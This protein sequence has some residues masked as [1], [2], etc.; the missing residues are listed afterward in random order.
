MTSPAGP[1][2]TGGDSGE[3]RLKLLAVTACPTG[4]AHTYM[5]A[6]KLAQAA[7]SRGIDMKVETQ[8]SIGAENV[9]DDNDVSSA[10]GIII[11][12]D[13]DV[14][15]SR[16]VGKRVL[17]VGVAEGIRHPEQLIERVRSAPVHTAGAAPAASASSGGRERS[18][19][20][21]ALMNGV[22]Y[23]IPFVVV[24]GLLIAIS[25]SL[26]GHTD[27]SGGLVIPKD[28][29]WMDVNNI[30]VIGFTL[31]VPILSGYIAYAIGDRPA[32]VPGMIGGWIANT[33]E[34]YDSKAGA[35]F[36]GAIVTGFLAGYLVLWIK[37]VK[38]PKFVQ[39]IMPIIVIPIVA[40][41]ALG[42]FFIYVIGKPISWV[43]EHLT[44]W[45]S[46]MTGTSAVLLGAILGLMIAFD[47]G[48]PVNKTAFLFGTGL[49][50]TG[51]QTVMGMCAAAIPVMPLGQGLA[52]LIRKRLYTEQERE[53]GLAAL[54][55]G[56][57]GI[58]EGAIPFAAA[59][60]A[61]VIPANMLGGAVAGAIAGVAGVEDAVP[62]GGPIVAVLGA[63]SGV[64]M[65][66]VAVVIGSV[67]TALTTVALIDFGER[68][69]GRGREHKG[70]TPV[71]GTGAV[72]PLEPELV[73]VGAGATAGGAVGAVV[74]QR[75]VAAS[76][77]TASAV[78]VAPGRTAEASYAGSG[79]GTEGGPGAG[80]DIGEAAAADA[81]SGEGAGAGAKSGAG[82]ESS[83]GGT[84]AAGPGDR[85]EPGARTKTAAGDAPAAAA[86]EAVGAPAAAAVEAA[87]SPAA[88]SGEAA[89]SP[90]VA[91]AEAASSPAAATTE[92]A[93][94]PAAEPTRAESESADSPTAGANREVLSGYLTEQ[95][96]KVSLGARG[97][98]D[99]IREMA[100]L[101]ART[102]KVADMDELVAVALRR[103][104]QGTTGLGEEIAIPHAKTD[105]VTSPVV[106]F[107]RSAEGIEWGSLDGTKARLVFMISVPEA[108]AGDEHLRILALLSRKLMDA[109]FRERLIGA[110]DERAI[111]GVLG[112]IR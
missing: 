72:G 106:G 48:G 37:K 63:V 31:M 95:T 81:E 91:T 44:D 54:F 27:P 5:A 6:E 107:A 99:A 18:V 62:H 24:G 108:A 88:A 94:S 64:P 15:L 46:G 68:G 8:G 61:Q 86:A 4:I 84:A 22:S 53:T 90:A 19:G 76:S 39:P 112:E 47:M 69:R 16:F 55:M 77:Q 78:E 52:T 89:S 87:D 41:T 96:V 65:F 38:V 97:K 57:F 33:G 11:A 49:I 13:K 14:D 103:E 25:L 56:C 83:S 7:A 50:A 1:P 21:K 35:G 23:M 109:G 34:L 36:I 17:T 3:Q 80:A 45:L 26:G 85:A 100:E 66:F 2:P 75:V 51:N 79:A 71:N 12:A 111:L 67:V 20:Y 42:L 70:A 102:G 82:A 43:F 110:P 60:P 74:A 104:E 73:G 32:L 28:S 105:A 58:S 92:A 98:E 29:F 30:G 93:S 40:T 59:R 9:L 10:D 101:L